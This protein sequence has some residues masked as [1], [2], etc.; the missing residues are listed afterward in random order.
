M[1][2]LTTSARVVLV[3]LL[4]AVLVASGTAATG[5]AKPDPTAGITAEK[6]AIGPE[7]ARAGDY[8][9]ALYYDVNKDVYGWSSRKST[10]RAANRA[11]YNDCKRNARSCRRVLT[12]RNSCA[13]LAVRYSNGRVV[14][15]AWGYHPKSHWTALRNARTKVGADAYSR[16]KFC[17]HWTLF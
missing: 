2:T 7:N 12:L 1:H 4:A 5:A 15:A 6:G 10:S 16:T 3:A 11:A 8:Y 9:G 14:E 13:G 17:A